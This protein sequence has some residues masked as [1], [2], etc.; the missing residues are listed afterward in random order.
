M[1]APDRSGNVMAGAPSATLVREQ[2]GKL[3]SSAQL[4]NAE[5][6]SCL[7]RF[8]VD[9]TLNGRGSQLKEVR[10]LASRLG[11]RPIRTILRSIQ[12]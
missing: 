9:E 7:L 11:A 12:S 6:L 5:R 10:E 3:L 1:S 4:A 2:L 8:I